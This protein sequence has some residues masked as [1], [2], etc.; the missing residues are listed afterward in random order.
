MFWGDSFGLIRGDS[1][2]L[3]R[4]CFS[5]GKGTRLRGC[6]RVYA[7]APGRMCACA[8]VCACVRNA[9]VCAPV[10]MCARGCGKNVTHHGRV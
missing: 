1:F 2:L 9:R 10:C 7:L 3:I 6:A 5:R 4:F 8:Y